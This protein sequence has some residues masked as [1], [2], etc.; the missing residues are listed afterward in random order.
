MQ[1]SRDVIIALDAEFDYRQF[2]REHGRVKDH[3]PYVEDII[4][5]LDEFDAFMEAD[6][7]NIP[8]DY[9]AY[10]DFVREE[11]KKYRQSLASKKYYE[12][13]KGENA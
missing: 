1:Y 10:H 3:H 12:K 5:L 11:R 4:E 6:E 7:V 13:K 9:S 8:K 2:L